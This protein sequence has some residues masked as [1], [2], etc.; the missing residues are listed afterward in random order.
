MPDNDQRPSLKNDAWII[1]TA[2]VAVIII[3]FTDFGANR[4]KVYDCR[5]AHWHPDV[6]IEV[7]KE[8]DRIMYE[9][10][11]KRQEEESKKKTITT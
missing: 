7:K 3:L 11:K 5:D 1:V 9:N 10:W 2:L 8:C 6:P 4:G